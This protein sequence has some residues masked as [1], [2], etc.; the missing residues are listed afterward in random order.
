MGFGYPV[1]VVSVPNLKEISTKDKFLWL[2][3]KSWILAIFIP[4]VLLPWLGILY[5]LLLYGWFLTFFSILEFF[6]EDIADILIA[7]S[8]IK[9]P[10]DDFYA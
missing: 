4:F 5:S 3:A 1:V 2:N 8:Q 9:T 10:G 7:Y 6:D